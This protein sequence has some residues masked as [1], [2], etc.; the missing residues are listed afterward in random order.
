MSTHAV[1]KIEGIDFAKI[2]KHCDGMP[3]AMLPFLTHFNKEF[4]KELGRDD[5]QYKFAQLL[6]AS[7][8]LEKEYELDNSDTEG[9]GVMSMKDKADER[10]IYTLYSDGDVGYDV[11]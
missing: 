7:K 9:W 6:R 4:I 2:Y 1:I 8:R 10:F 11:R 5:P 3:E